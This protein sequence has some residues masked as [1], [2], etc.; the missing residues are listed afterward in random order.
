MKKLLFIL[1]LSA[2]ASAPRGDRTL[3]VLTYNIHAARGF[4]LNVPEAA[5]LTAAPP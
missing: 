1:M 4:P 5:P 3:R 2:C